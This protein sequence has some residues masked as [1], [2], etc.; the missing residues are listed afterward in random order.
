ME[1]TKTKCVVVNLLFFLNEVTK[2]LLC[3][4]DWPYFAEGT[5]ASVIKKLEN[6]RQPVVCRFSGIFIFVCLSFQDSKLINITPNRAL[7]SIY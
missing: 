2:A 4:S 6:P 5:P 3:E 1:T 7:E